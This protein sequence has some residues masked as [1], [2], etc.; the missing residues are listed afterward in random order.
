MMLANPEARACLRVVGVVGV[1]ISIVKLELFESYP[2]DFKTTLPVVAPEGT[3]VFMAVAAQPPVPHQLATTLEVNVTRSLVVNAGA[4]TR[5]PS[6][7][8]SV[9]VGHVPLWQK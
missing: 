9:P 3:C 2:F 6:V 5:S 7:A 4:F 1:G 8:P